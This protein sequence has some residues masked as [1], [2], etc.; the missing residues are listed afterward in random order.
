M[1]ELKT[2]PQ[3][4]SASKGATCNL[5]PHIVCAGANDAIDFYKKAFGAQELTRIPGKDGKLMHGA[6]TINGA[7]VMLTD[8][9]PQYG[10]LSPKSLNGTSV[11][12]HLNVDDVDAFMATAQA[13]GAN[14]IMPA[15]DMFWGDRYG[16]LVDP[17]GHRWS[18]ATHQ[19]DL[20]PEELMT[21]AREFQDK[22]NCP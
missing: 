17:F 2:K 22:A 5:A 10:S 6:I 20:T 13:A 7:T 1:S 19:R 4:S 8:E 18:I 12:L 15:A 16:V 3:A 21:A 11:T 14:I 9:S